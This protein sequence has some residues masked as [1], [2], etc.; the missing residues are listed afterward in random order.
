[1]W[2]WGRPRQTQLR[3]TGR[4]CSGHER[5]DTPRR[6]SA[7]RI[8][9]G[10]VQG[11][12]MRTILG[13]KSS[14]RSPLSRAVPAGNLSNEL[15]LAVDQNG[16]RSRTPGVHGPRLSISC[17]VSRKNGVSVSFMIYDSKAIPLVDHLL[18][19]HPMPVSLW[20][21]VRRPGSGENVVG[22]WPGH[23]PSRRGGSLHRSSTDRPESQLARARHWP[24]SPLQGRT[25]EC[26]SRNA[27]AGS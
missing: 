8:S 27:S 11:V 1:M 15:S 13:L 2:S 21:H 18:Y 14:R 9:G 17:F 6:V 16:G 22:R 25:A 12:E 7:I 5:S 3:G 19:P 23:Q 26:E 24:V 20:H 10:R 4:E